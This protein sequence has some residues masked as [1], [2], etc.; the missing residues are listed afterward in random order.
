[1]LKYLERFKNDEEGAITVDWVVLTAAIVGMGA[2]AVTGLSGETG[3]VSDRTSE[4]I[5]RQEPRNN[6]DIQ[7]VYSGS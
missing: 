2:I 1:M 5:E 4:Y 6:A 3:T 7:A